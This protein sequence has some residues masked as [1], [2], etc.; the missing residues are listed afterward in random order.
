MPTTS[1]TGTLPIR[2]KRFALAHASQMASHDGVSVEVVDADLVGWDVVLDLAS[3]SRARDVELVA[4]SSSPIPEPL[5][6]RTVNFGTV[7]DL[8]DPGVP[9]GE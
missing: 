9:A 6:E 4:I 3:R 1:N 7:L 2:S 8:M 5:K